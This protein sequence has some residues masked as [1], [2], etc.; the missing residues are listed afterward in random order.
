MMRVPTFD[1]HPAVRAG[2]DTQGAS[3]GC[4]PDVGVRRR[5]QARSMTS[6]TYDAVLCDLDGVLAPTAAL[7]ARCWKETFDLS[8]TERGRSGGTYPD[9]S[10]ADRDHLTHVDVARSAAP[11]ELR[12]A[13][14]HIAVADLAEMLP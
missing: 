2:L 7:H 13:G 5:R 1:R 4:A 12:S 6:V 3:S 8:P 11:A 10:D 9:P 14:A